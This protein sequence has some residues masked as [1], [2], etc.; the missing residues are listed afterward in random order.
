MNLTTCPNCKMRVL[1]KSD[2][3]CPSCQAII[4]QKENES[5][6]QS[7]MAI[8]TNVTNK[9]LKQEPPPMTS[10]VDK[11]N[12]VS[13][14]VE[15]NETAKKHFDQSYKNWEKSKYE[16]ALEECDK[17]I[18]LDP[19]MSEAHNLRGVILEEMDKQD[20]SILEYREAIRLNPNYQDAKENLAYADPTE[21][22][23]AHRRAKAAK[24][25]PDDT[26]IS[27][28]AAS[29]GI[30]FYFMNPLLG[31][32]PGGALGHWLNGAIGGGLGAVVG[33]IINSLRR[34]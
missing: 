7:I 12:N 21:A 15:N 23:K 31:I 6:P 25:I 27:T 33:I 26:I 5:I 28:F 11:G 22:A 19:N 34:K 2:G 10:A 9:P 8:K 3:T 17:A 29:G 14:K 24:R 30:L 13:S 18:D 32:I 1:P 16:K 20:D 4:Q